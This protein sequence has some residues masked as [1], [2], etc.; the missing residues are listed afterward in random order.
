MDRKAWIVTTLC[1]I[2]M[3]WYLGIENPRYQKKVREYR[4]QVDAEEMARKSVVEENKVLVGEAD[5]DEA[6]NPTGEV[7]PDGGTDPTGTTPSEPAAT[8]IAAETIEL[9]TNDEDGNPAVVFTL[10]NKGGGIET[11]QLLQHIS[12][13]DET[14]PIVLNSYADH[15]IGA[16]SRKIGE[17]DEQAYQ[18]VSKSDTEV[19][20]EATT[21]ELVKVTKTYSLVEPTEPGAAYRVNLEMTMTNTDETRRYSASDYYIYAGAIAALK[22]KEFMQPDYTSVLY[23]NGTKYRNRDVNYFKKKE[24][25]INY[26][27]TTDELLWGGPMNQ[28]FVQNICAETAYSSKIWAQRFP[29]VLEGYTKEQS[30]GHYAVHSGIGMPAVS[31]DPGKSVTHKYQFYLG[32]KKLKPL[33]EM[34]RDRERIMRYNIVPILGGIAAPVSKFL[35]SILLWIQAHVHNYGVAILIMTVLLRTAMWPIYAKSQKTMKRMSKLSPKMTALREKHKDNPQKMQ[36]E[37]AKLFKENGRGPLGPLGGCL[38]MLVQIPVFLGFFQMLRL[39]VE[40]RHEPFI[41]WVTDLSQPDTLFTIPGIGIPLNILPILMAVTMIW[42][43]RVTPSSGDPTQKKL[44]MIMPVIF[45]VFCYNFASA[46]ALYWT[47]QNLFSIG[48][49]YLSKNKKD[50]EPE[51]EPE[52]SPAEIAKKRAASGGGRTGGA[53]AKKKKKNP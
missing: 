15:A 41:A 17:V 18:I 23:K 32:A 7:Q 24:A 50:D 34:G 19:V 37:T 3:I 11:A 36:Q 20:F 1:V 6:T 10:T 38:P 29:V 47:G 26:N 33:K 8:E 2:G 53:R 12:A 40:L 22:P 49:T 28:Y 52:L 35:L 16:L 30:D 21:A 9:R 51:K 48:Q 42:Q 14:T 27:P 43:M 45:L 39:A 31:L 25:K 5:G 4:E 44:M 46:L 13:Y